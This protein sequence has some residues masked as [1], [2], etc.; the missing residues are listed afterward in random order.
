MHLLEMGL[1]A[2][3]RVSLLFFIMV[4]W[5]TLGRRANPCHIHEEWKRGVIFLV[6]GLSVILLAVA[7][8][9]K[10]DIEV[11][12]SNRDNEVALG[13]LAL[14][15]FPWIYLTVKGFLQALLAK[16]N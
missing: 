5:W 16:F 14:F 11:G 12:R 3:A 15:F 6:L 4:G 10:N 9:W 8:S 1:L 2:F 13:V 7:I